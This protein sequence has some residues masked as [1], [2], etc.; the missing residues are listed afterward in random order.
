MSRFQ[1]AKMYVEAVRPV[2]AAGTAFAAKI[3]KWT[4]KTSQ[5]TAETEAKPYMQALVKLRP[6]LISLARSYPPAAAEVNRMIT[7]F[8][9]LLTDLKGVR[10]QPFSPG[11]WAQ[12]IVSDATKVNPIAARVRAALGLPA[13]AA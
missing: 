5:A 9:P 3:K 12:T 1:A 7:A 11:P 6:E 13:P 2:N 8:E 10:D 4:T